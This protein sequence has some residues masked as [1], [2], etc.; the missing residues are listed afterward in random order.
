MRTRAAVAFTLAFVTFALNASAQPRRTTRPRNEEEASGEVVIRRERP[1]REVT[2]RTVEQREITRIPGTNG[3]ALRAVQNMP[4]VARAP[5]ITGLIVVR[6]AAPEDTAF[7][8]DGSDIPLVYHFGGLTSVMPSDLLE[9]IDF[10]PGNFA[11]RYGRAQAGIIDVGIRSPRGDRIHAM[12]NISVID[13]GFRVEGPITRHL[14]FLVSARRSWVD[15]VLGFVLETVNA[16][17]APLS[18]PV[19]YDWQAMLEWTPTPRDRI[20]LFG[21]GSDDRLALL[22]STPQDVDPTIHGRLSTALWFHRAQL[23]W[24]HRFTPT[25]SL[26]VMVSAGRDVNAVNFGRLADLTVDRVPI[27]SR[28]EYNRPIARNARWNIGFDLSSGPARYT[29]RGPRPPSFGAGVITSTEDLAQVATDTTGTILRPALWTDFEF[30]PSPAL[31]LI[32]SVRI[33]YFTEINRVT[34]SPRVSFRVRAAPSWWIKGGVGLFT[35]PPQFEQ[36]LDTP[37]VA[38][39][40]GQRV[41]N[42]NL[43]PQRAMH[44]GLGFEHD[45]TPQISLSVEGF[46][47]S[48]EDLVA[49]PG[50]QR[51]LIPYVNSGASRAYGMELMLRHRPG[52][53]F[54]GWIAYT[55]SRSIIRARP[56]E[57]YDLS[58]FDQTHILTAVANV[59]L[60]RGWEVGA[61]FRFVSGVPDALL[62]GTLYNADTWVYVPFFE[63]VASSRVPAFH[64]LDLRVDKTF[65]FRHWTLGLFLDVQNV[66]NHANAEFTAYSF[67]Y[68]QRGVTRGLPIL[69]SLGIRGEL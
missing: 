43:R 30:T 1:A 51:A 63:P 46:F 9:R 48:V 2:R 45:F 23:T 53:R 64:Q 6:G 50:D 24:E 26:R 25:S 39:R 33:D 62:T 41:G 69:P 29:F 55:L 42:P 60:G 44:Y 11:A 21:F 61:R 40:E 22:F 32:P 57:P 10:Y 14:T 13:A 28:I 37:N 31:R 35:Q 36:T 67:D 56:G 18:L 16:G 7:F 49:Q 66:Y 19:Y 47:R 17:V 52:T 20:R 12:A 27:T 34:V 8:A 68:R 3:D 59:R 65:T 5:L 54:F 58:D 15:A 4:G 38:S